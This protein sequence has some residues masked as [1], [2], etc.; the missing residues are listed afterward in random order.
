MSDLLASLIVTGCVFAGGCLGLQLHRVLP[1]HHLTKETLDVIRLGIGMVSVLASL[2][3]GLLIATAKT[4]SDT[5]DR[6]IRAY[7][8]D[9][10][11]LDRLLRSYGGETA[12]ARSLLRRA[13]ERTL[14]DLWPG[15]DESF[16]GIDDASAGG[17]LEQVQEMIAVLPANDPW[18]TWLRQQA[19]QEIMSLLRQRWL[20]IEQLGSSIKPAIL[21][22]LIMWTFAIFVSFGLNAPRN[23]T[24]VVAFLIISIAIGGAV[25]LILEMDSQ[26]R[27]LL[28]LSDLPLQKALA[29]MGGDAGAAGYPSRSGSLAMP[30]R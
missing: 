4:A 26:F 8:A 21:I 13:T 20:M 6:E 10:V 11:L 2:V 3:F 17:L 14:R 5:G 23:A 30:A 12:T 19:L 1:K 7:A 18:K 29:E 15:P 16:V 28:R 9:T 27:G 22:V 25:F 24:V